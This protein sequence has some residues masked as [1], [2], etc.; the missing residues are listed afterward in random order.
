M[1]NIILF[2][3]RIVISKLDKIV[4]KN[5]NFVV[6][7]SFPDLSDNSFALFL[8]IIKNY[9]T[10]LNIWL[11]K[12]KINIKHHEMI[13]LYTQESNYKLIKRDSF[14]GIYYYLRAKY[15]FFTHGIY[16]GAQISSSHC[17]VN[18]WHGMPLKT[19][20]LLGSSEFIQKSTYAI[21]TSNFYKD[22]M[23]RAFGLEKKQVLITGQP[24]NDLMKENINCFDKLNIDNNKKCILWTPTY[25]KSNIGDI[26]TDGVDE[27]YLPVIKNDDFIKLNTF[28]EK[29]NYQLI[30]KLHPMDNLNTKEFNQYSNI[31]I[32][33]KNDF[34][35]SKIQLYSLLGQ[36]NILLTDFSSIYID[37][38]LTGNPIAFLNN[39]ID[40]YSNTRG[41]I[42]PNPLDYMPGPQISNY[43][44][45]IIYLESIINNDDIYIEQR[46]QINYELNIITNS[47]SEELLKKINFQ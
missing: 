28:L 25:R 42:F 21:C 32:L 35:D 22:I 44:D 40:E 27:N 23:S 39:D 5:N 43:K 36:V 9:P 2:F 47:Y 41:F 16:S 29:I 15:V 14:L 10:K 26:R 20:A 3:I 8:H 6:Y 33:N 13:K 46:K 19:I 34:E 45:L 12:D 7:N 4:R 38:L 17:I 11:V 30:I 1:R 18:L 31:L 24:R 37:Y